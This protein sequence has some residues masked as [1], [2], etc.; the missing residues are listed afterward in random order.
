MPSAKATDPLMIRGKLI[1]VRL[2]TMKQAELKFFIDNPRIYSVVHEEG[3]DTTQ[4]EIEEIL[5]KQDHVRELKES[6]KANNGLIEHLF[7]K[8]RT[9]EVVE[10]N[11]RLAA[12]RLLFQENPLKWSEVKCALLPSD[13][14][15]SLMNSFLGEIHLKGKKPWSPYE[16]ASFLHRRFRN[17]GVSVDDLKK[18]FNISKPAIEHSIAV[19]DLME[20]HEEKETRRWSYY[21]EFKK[22]RKAKA[23]CANVANFEDVIVKQIKLDEVGTAMEFRDKLRVICNSSSKNPVKNLVSEKCDFGDAFDE[24]ERTGGD[25]RPLQRIK[26]FRR[27]LDDGHTKTAVRNASQKIRGELEYELHKIRAHVEKLLK[28]LG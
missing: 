11:R 26:S 9:L 5:K 17:D 24:A 7:V 3:K 20:K 21:D 2:C 12:Y 1:P 8:E 6:I 28:T 14:D 22:S 4:E 18:E 23:I 10:G 19:I 13:L 15:E 16:K 27:W 25:N